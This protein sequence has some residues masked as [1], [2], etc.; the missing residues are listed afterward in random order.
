MKKSIYFLFTILSISLLFSCKKDCESGVVF[1]DE[2][3]E[4]S[5][6][7]VF[8]AEYDN[9]TC[10]ISFMFDIHYGEEIDV[11]KY[12]YS[13]SHEPHV[14]LN[15][16]KGVEIGQYLNGGATCEVDGNYGDDITQYYF[17]VPEE[18][19]QSIPVLL[20]RFNRFTF[21]T[22]DSIVVEFKR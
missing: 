3:L 4:D 6:G 15:F 21:E 9:G 18:D 14:A 12:Q 8:Q 2:C 22:L 17:H 19:A 11:Y 5:G 10:N 7:N 13:H 16:A 1:F 20:K